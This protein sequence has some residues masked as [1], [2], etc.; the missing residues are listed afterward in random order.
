M[1]QKLMKLIAPAAVLGATA[2]PM[3]SSTPAEAAVTH[4]HHWT[5]HTVNA[6]QRHQQSRILRGERNGAL[7]YR[8]ADRLERR[9]GRI[10]AIEARDRRSGGR[11]T[12]RERHQVQRDLNQESRAI[13]RQKHDRQD[14][15]NHRDRDD[16]AGRRD[17]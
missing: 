6:R 12:T 14:R 4:H 9:E 10:N 11:F 7:T 15:D 2:L 13:Y 16:H 5:R 8:E 17:R 3:L 1:K